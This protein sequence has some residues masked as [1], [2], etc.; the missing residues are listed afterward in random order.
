MLRHARPF[1]DDINMKYAI[2]LA[3]RS[4]CKR[5]QVGCVVT[6][7]KY[8]QVYAIGY[9]GGA[10]K[11]E[12]LCSGESGGC[13][14]VHAEINALI[15]CRVDDNNKVMFTT[16]YPCK[17]CAK[18]IVNSGF[19][20]IYYLGDYRDMGESKIVFKRA[21]IEVV[22]KQ[23]WVMRDGRSIDVTRMKDD[24][25]VNAIK[26]LEKCIAEE[27]HQ[28]LNMPPSFSGEMAQ[29]YADLEY[30]RM[31][32]G[33]PELMAYG[34]AKWMMLRWEA[35]SRKLEGYESEPEEGDQGIENI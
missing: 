30:S 23:Y 26:L 10:A 34:D 1:H 17:T 8:T 29:Y 15:K 6:D 20:R 33:G 24:H 27:W 32:D 31:A 5:K 9:N 22:K 11:Q 7:Q 19:S 28:A 13:G 14:C 25:L 18:A 12:C 4:D 21:G 35:Y 16:C 2:N 3:E